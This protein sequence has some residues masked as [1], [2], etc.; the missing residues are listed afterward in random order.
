M[1]WTGT[2]YHPVPSPSIFILSL[3]RFSL[4]SSLLLDSSSL[5]KYTQCTKSMNITTSDISVT[6]QAIC[7]RIFLSFFFSLQYLLSS[8]S[9]PA[10][11]SIF[12]PSQFFFPLY[13]NTSNFSTAFSAFSHYIFLPL[14]LLSL[15]LLYPSPWKR[16][17]M[18]FLREK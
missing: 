3:S 14:F 8:I 1:T 10:S 16:I 17:K 7:Y 18:T 2:L 9:N 4:F 13:S 11:L 5:S 12:Y 15:C 6:I